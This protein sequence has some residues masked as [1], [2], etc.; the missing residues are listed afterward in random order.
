MSIIYIQK[1]TKTETRLQGGFCH[2]DYVK[3]I[4]MKIAHSREDKIPLGVFV[5]LS[6]YN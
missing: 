2:L 5:H 1:K 4:Y 6:L 3:I